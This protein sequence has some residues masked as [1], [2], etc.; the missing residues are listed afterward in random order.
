MTSVQKLAVC[1]D[2]AEQLKRYRVGR[3]QFEALIKH[4]LAP[5]DFKKVM[6]AYRLAKYGHRGQARDCGGRYFE[7]PKAVA[8]IVIQE[9]GIFRSDTIA[10]ALLHD[11]QEDSFIATWEDVEDFFGK[12]VV[13]WVRALTKEG[14]KD[15]FSNLL[16][17]DPD[18]L[19]VK[20]CDRLH[21]L[22]TLKGCKREKQLGQILET[23][24]KLSKVIAVLKK[25]LNRKELWHA[26]YLEIQ[27][28]G[29][30]DKIEKS[31]SKRP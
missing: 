20:C 9:L 2:S 8:L 5:S 28:F 25:K 4:R 29:E 26:E 11:L 24:E 16:S 1:K 31:L 18:V 6:R 19:L 23:R 22:R 27:I 10:S 13:R 15:Y 12:K 21:N 7:H 30:C 14:D 3:Q 17:S